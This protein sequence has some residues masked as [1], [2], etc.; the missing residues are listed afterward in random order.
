[1]DC[2][3]GWRYISVAFTIL[4]VFC[5]Y[6]EMEECGQDEL[7]ACSRPLQVLTET[8]E[9]SFVTKKS[10]LDKL[11]PDLHAGLQCIRSYTRRCMNLHQ[12][13]HFNKLYHG[14]G[15]VIHELCEDGPY[16][17]DFLR[18]APCMRHVKSE[19]EL[20]SKRYQNTM[21]RISQ[22]TPNEH[23]LQQQQYYQQQSQQQYQQQYQ[24][25]QPLNNTRTDD[26]GAEG[27]RAVCC[28][29]KE[30]I[31]C[32]EYTVKRTCGREAAFFTRT[33][34]DRISNSLMRMHCENYHSEPGECGEPSA[35]TRH[36]FSTLC[37]VYSA[38]FVI[39][40]QRFV[41]N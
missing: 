2:K 10:E 28:A 14:T 21:T 19:Y 15:E 31:A 17:E 1:M 40:L 3:I 18:H 35:S 25:Q 8:S 11:C 13:T 34:L 39:A 5:D 12:R 16:Q 41:L 36:I 26:D 33:F 7:A 20:C 30:Y 29:F 37:S 38:L 4:S 9:L 27:I 32:S 6:I 22:S 24:Q 23:E